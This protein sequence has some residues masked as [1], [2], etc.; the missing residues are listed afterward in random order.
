MHFTDLPA[1]GNI[2]SLPNRQIDAVR[3]VYNFDSIKEGQTVERSY[4]TVTLSQSSYPALT[5]ESL[6]GIF[7]QTVEPFNVKPRDFRT[8]IERDSISFIVYDRNQ[9]DTQIINS[10][11]LQLIYSNDRYVI[12]KILK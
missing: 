1:W 10:K 2:G 12:F 8:Y 3:F 11:I 6:Q 4:Q 7:S 5:R 9:L